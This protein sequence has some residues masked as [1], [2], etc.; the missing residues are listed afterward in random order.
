MSAL[1]LAAGAV[2]AVDLTPLADLETRHAS[3][4]A[5]L[6][7][8]VSLPREIE[9]AIARAQRACSA[10]IDA[11]CAERE[12]LSDEL[13]A[14]REALRLEYRIE[15][16]K[17]FKRSQSADD[18]AGLLLLALIAGTGAAVFCG[19]LVWR[20][21]VR[22]SPHA[23]PI[24]PPPRGH[25]QLAPSVPPMAPPVSPFVAAASVRAEAREWVWPGIVARGDVT[26]LGG[27]PKMG[28]SQIALFA[29]AT[30]SRG[31]AWP[32]GER[33]RRGSALICE[34]EDDVAQDVQPRLEALGADMSR[35]A[36]GGPLDLSREIGKLEAHA[37][38]VGD[39]RLVVLS[40][41]ISFFGPSSTDEVTVRARLAPL[42]EWGRERRVAVVG[43][44]HV[45]GKSGAGDAFSGSEAYRRA[46]RA[47]WKVVL[48]P[49]DP[50]PN[51][52]R[53]RRLLIAVGVNN[54]ADDAQLA[55]RIEGVTL[56]SGIE[57]SRV[58]FEPVDAGEPVADYFPRGMYEGQPPTPRPVRR[59]AS[60]TLT[61]AADWLRGMLAEGPKLATDLKV[62]AAAAGISVGTL[63]TAARQLGVQMDSDGD[64]TAPKTWRLPAS[65]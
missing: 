63:Y 46:A 33:A 36:F 20:R 11:A 49:A 1:A 39:L 54:A 23:A 13:A 34:L 56:P 60:E 15:K 32:G 58:R 17:R 57:T 28:K 62:A 9:A 2:W 51:P 12:R 59:A 44:T 24:Q 61:S 64:V 37:R 6:G 3:L 65:A 30:L 14:T 8:G 47:A 45:T 42:L 29:A 38:A 4:L 40:P 43:V 52:K 26:L 19:G 55:Y 21:A 18:G 50:E 41:F 25:Y 16:Q 10:G 48:D 31:D 35:I 27:A 22:P 7:G 53:K 5:Q